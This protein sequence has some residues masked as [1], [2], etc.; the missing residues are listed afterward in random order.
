MQ[1]FYYFCHMIELARHIEWLLGEHDCVIV[2]ELGGFIT[3]YVPSRWIEA[4][5]LF[6]PPTRM[7][8]FN[9][10]LR[11]NDGLLVQSYMEVHHAGFAEASKMVERDVRHF[12]EALHENGKAC[13]ENIGELCVSMDGAY[14]FSPFDNKLSTS[15][16]YGLGSFEMSELKAL[17]PKP[18][19]RRLPVSKRLYTLGRYHL[20][21]LRAAHVLNIL[22][23]V[24]IVGLFFFAPT[25]IENT[26][27]VKGNY[28]RLLPENLFENFEKQSLAMTP[29]AV[30]ETMPAAEDFSDIQ[31]KREPIR[32]VRVAEVKVKETEKQTVSVAQ[33]VATTQD[34]SST[35]E[36]VN[37][38]IEKRYHV[39]VASM[40]TEKDAHDMVKQ[41][42]EKGYTDAEAII[43]NG[44][45]RVCIHSCKTESEAY[46][47]IAALREEGIFKDAWV[48]KQ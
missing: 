46:R 31:K 10:H 42:I 37:T 41:L 9:P 48:L 26:E 45:R 3:H 32:P 28:A 16:L 11:M 4:E 47:Y 36:A 18:V 40:G 22:A 2:P 21:Q 25:P 5:H 12:M 6:L 33:G 38:V 20:R 29:I 44:K 7:V 30:R 23:V 13:L 8:A 35:T 39:I 1:Y 17:R 43:G 19:S 34:E 24:F 27:V 14:R 15:F